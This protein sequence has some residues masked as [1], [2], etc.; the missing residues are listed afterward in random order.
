MDH[1]FDLLL[2]GRGV[3]GFLPKVDAVAQPPKKVPQVY[4][5]TDDK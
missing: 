1:A 2:G 3:A 5:K 4:G